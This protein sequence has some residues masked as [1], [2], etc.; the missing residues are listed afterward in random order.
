PNGYFYGIDVPAGTT[1]PLNV[2]V[3]DPAFVHVGDNCGTSDG[4]AN[5]SLTNAATLTAANIPGYS[6][7]SPTITPATRYAPS[8]S[9]AY[10]TGDNYYADGSNTANPWTVWTLRAPDVSTWDP[11]NNPIVCQAEFPGVYPE[12]SNYAPN[13][14]VDGNALKNLL[15]QSTNYP[16]TNPAR[17]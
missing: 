17:T 3:F 6:T 1:G 8:G 15:Q 13:G 9:S 12:T 14:T 16:G 11:T 7:M 10:C 4:N 2:Q 5:T